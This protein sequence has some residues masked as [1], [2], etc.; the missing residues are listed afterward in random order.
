MKIDDL[1][2]KKSSINQNTES[3]Q[4]NLTGSSPSKIT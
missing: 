3:K 1:L 4:V 2:H